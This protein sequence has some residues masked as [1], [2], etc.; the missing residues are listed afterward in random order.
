MFPNTDDAMHNEILSRFDGMR[1]RIAS[2]HIWTR[3]FAINRYA[4]CK[5][6]RKYGVDWTVIEA[7]LRSRAPKGSFSTKFAEHFFPGCGWFPL[8]YKDGRK[9]LFTILNGGVH[10]SV[11]QMRPSRG[12]RAI[13]IAF[14]NG[15]CLGSGSG[16]I[17]RFGSVNDAVDMVEWMEA[18]MDRNP[19]AAWRLEI[20]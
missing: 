5:R 1:D 13:W 2:A 11:K 4:L 10:A 9:G 19:T 6:L 3:R 17:R 16:R 7:F 15:H 20:N 12:G 18:L 8:S 14:F